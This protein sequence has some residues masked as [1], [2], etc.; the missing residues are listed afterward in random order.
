MLRSGLDL[1]ALVDDPVRR[2]VTA[3]GLGSSQTAQWLAEHRPDIRYHCPHLSPYPRATQQ[4]LEGLVESLLPSPIGLIGSSL[5]GFWATWL[6]EKYDLRAVLINPAVDLAM[7]RHEMINVSL[8]NYHTDD[9]Y[10]LKEEHVEVFRSVEVPEVKR[11]E[12]YLLMVQTGDEVLDYRLAVRKYAGGSHVVEEGGDHTFS[13]FDQRIPEAI[14]FLE[15]GAGGA[16]LTGRLQGE[17]L[18]RA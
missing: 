6:A 9:V 8:K 18:M 2:S 15:S 14:S 5:G 13:N 7:F 10:M 16:E 11:P 4:A 3:R 1:G 17:M 12:N